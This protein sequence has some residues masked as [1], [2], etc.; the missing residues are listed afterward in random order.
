M[1]LN[2]TKPV[3]RDGAKG[4]EYLSMAAE[5]GSV[6]AMLDLANAYDAYLW[7]DTVSPCRFSVSVFR[8]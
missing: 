8:F 5:K 4:V 7:I 6:Q 2:G 1:H 3:E